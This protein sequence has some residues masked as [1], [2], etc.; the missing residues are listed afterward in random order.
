[1][2]RTIEAIITP[3]PEP[4][5]KQEVT[6]QDRTN[7][8]TSLVL[9]SIAASPQ[10]WGPS[11]ILGEKVLSPQTRR[12]IH[13]TLQE[14]VALDPDEQFCEVEVEKL[15]EPFRKFFTQPLPKIS[16][17]QAREDAKTMAK[18]TE[19]KILSTT[20]ESIHTHFPHLESDLFIVT[21]EDLLEW[22]QSVQDRFTRVRRE[23]I[24]HLLDTQQSLREHVRD[25]FIAESQEA[26]AENPYSAANLRNKGVAG[27]K[28]RIFT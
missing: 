2:R 1:M 13:I 28:P 20:I 23:H 12:R 11:S 18:L 27:T 15:Y 19:G 4:E 5:P 26:L 25:I 8:V 22:E 21:Y 24:Q 9:R 7:L 17:A 10:F 16:G 6:G 14:L 3:E